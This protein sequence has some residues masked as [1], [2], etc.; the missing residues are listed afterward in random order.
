MNGDNRSK[1]LLVG[2]PVMVGALA[3][4]VGQHDPMAWP[5]MLLVGS[6][7]LLGVVSP[8]VAWRWAAMVGLAALVAN[9][10]AHSRG[11][12]A[13]AAAWMALTVLP[14]AAAT[15]GAVFAALAGRREPV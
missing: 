15:A 8:R 7:C 2:L 3:G 14:L 9:L 13:H 6:A 10:V 1:S 12:G 4:T 11:D 5:T